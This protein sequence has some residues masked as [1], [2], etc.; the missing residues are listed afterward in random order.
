MDSTEKYAV[1]ANLQAQ[2]SVE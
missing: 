1:T 2:Q